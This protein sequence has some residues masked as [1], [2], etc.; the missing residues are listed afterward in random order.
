M[1]P[2]LCVR[3]QSWTLGEALS[4]KSKPEGIEGKEEGG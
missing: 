1:D 2:R 3:V 4:V